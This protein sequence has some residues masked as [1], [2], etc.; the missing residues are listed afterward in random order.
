VHY[1]GKVA[2]EIADL[3]TAKPLFNSVIST[4]N[5]RSASFDIKNFYLNNPM[6]RNEYM[7]IRIRYIPT[8][9]MLQYDLAAIT[10]HEGVLVEF[11]KGM[12]GLP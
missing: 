3:I 1:P 10:R 11:R 7:W 2:T 5:A 6:S 12:Y 9:I 8:N 4:P